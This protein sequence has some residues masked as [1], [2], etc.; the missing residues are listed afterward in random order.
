[1]KIKVLYIVEAIY[2]IETFILVSGG[3]KMYQNRRFKN[4]GIKKGVI[5]V[6]EMTPRFS[7]DSI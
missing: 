6:A 7:Q 3:M 5:L 1:M 4:V 2:N